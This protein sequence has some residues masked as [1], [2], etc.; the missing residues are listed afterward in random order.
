[1]ND[2]AL[3]EKGSDLVCMQFFYIFMISG[4]SL[5]IPVSLHITLKTLACNHAK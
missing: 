5:T 1:M 2:A 4:N 3:V